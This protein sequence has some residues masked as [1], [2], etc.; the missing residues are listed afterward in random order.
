ME[1]YEDYP[2]PVASSRY[3]NM[4]TQGVNTKVGSVEPEF[5]KIC[6]RIATAQKRV[7]EGINML[8]HIADKLFGE[9]PEVDS[10]NECQPCRSGS[11]GDALDG[12]DNL[13]ARLGRLTSVVS[14]LTGIA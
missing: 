5:S 10:V 2:K 3:A 9:R 8:T 6:E 7:D 12:L 4:A 13:H 1:A 14:R 11:V